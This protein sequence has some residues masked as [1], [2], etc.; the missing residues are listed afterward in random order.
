[1]KKLLFLPLILVLSTNAH[2][3]SAKNWLGEIAGLVENGQIF[4]LRESVKQLGLNNIDQ[5]EIK[6]V[7][8]GNSIS[9]TYRNDDKDIPIASI[10][11]IISVGGLGDYELNKA[12]KSIVIRFKEHCPTTQMLK[13][14][15]GKQFKLAQMMS[16]PSLQTGRGIAH[17]SYYIH[18]PNNIISVEDNG[19]EWHINGTAEFK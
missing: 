1:M 11:H 17:H 9:Y 4:K 5:L 10:S 3:L 12:T 2:A 18:T 6:P 16:P 14:E 19:C 7:A 8:N 13:L 15:F